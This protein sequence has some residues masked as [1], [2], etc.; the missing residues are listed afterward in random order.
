M[1]RRA[2]CSICWLAPGGMPARCVMTC[3]DYVVGHLG[4]LDVVLVAGETRDVKKGTAFAG[5]ARQYSVTAGKAGNC[6][7]AVF[8]TMPRA[9]SIGWRRSVTT[10]R[11][12]PGMTLSSP[13]CA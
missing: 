1:R 11:R 3:C 5:V 13:V 12:G 7:V 10:G 2:G 4:A 6:Q 8:L 9:H